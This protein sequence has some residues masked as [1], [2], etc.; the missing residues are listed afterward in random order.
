MGSK[1]DFAAAVQTHESK[2]LGMSTSRLQKVATA[3]VDPLLELIKVG[4]PIA[5]H[6]VGGF[7]GGDGGAISTLLLTEDV[8]VVG[9]IVW[10]EF[11]V[12]EEIGIDVTTAGSEGN[13]YTAL[14]ADRGDGYP[15]ELIHASAALTVTPGAFKSTASL[16]IELPPGLYWGGAVCNQVTTTVAT[17]RSLTNNSRY[18]GETAGANDVATAGYSQAAV[19]GAP[20]TNFTDTATVVGAVPRLLMKIKSV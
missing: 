13:L 15:G 7:Y 12:I 18:V 6:R 9:P 10:E 1:S 19:T 14:Y 5:R 16:D 2:R 20:P 3:D 11:A 8:L 4:P 17:V